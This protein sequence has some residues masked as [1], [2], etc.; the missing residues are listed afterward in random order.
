MSGS[1]DF[2]SFGVEMVNT[3]ICQLH[4][5]RNA[6]FIQTTVRVAGHTFAVQQAAWRRHQRAHNVP[7]QLDLVSA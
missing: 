1:I 4:F 3:T 6:L 5:L 2:I 7:L